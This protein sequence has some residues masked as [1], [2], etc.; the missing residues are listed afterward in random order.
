MATRILRRIACL[1]IALGLG[2]LWT[3]TPA[4]ANMR[5]ELASSSGKGVILTDTANTGV[6]TYNGPVDTMFTTN[7]TTGTSAPPQALNPPS[8]ASLDLN[9]INVD[10][11]GAGTLTIILENAGYTGPIT[12][13]LASA[14]IGGT[15]PNGA[16]VSAT[17]WVSPT[18]AVPTFTADQGP[19]LLPGGQPPALPAAG[20]DVQVLSFS[21]SGGG[22]F[23][24]AN[25]AV[26]V[27][28]NNAGTFSLYQEIVITFTKAGTFSANFSNQVSPEPSTMALAGLGA[29]GM[30][31]YGL[32][33]RK[34]LGA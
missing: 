19:G 3:P 26:G 4:Q 11:K 1:A 18:N 30:I 23:A 2:I 15:L 5:L 27:N 16:S 7:V 8:I 29:L 9:S 33:R 12:K 24:S 10:S 14:A 21:K 34:A 20:S 25:P 32:R 17:A 31:G 6:L 28:F 13:L 22:A